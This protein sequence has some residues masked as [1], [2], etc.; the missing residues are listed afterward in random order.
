MSTKILA[1]V[2]GPLDGM[3]MSLRRRPEFLWVEVLCDEHGMPV[4]SGCFTGPGPERVLYRLGRAKGT[5]VYAGHSHAL[6]GGCGAFVERL[7]GHVAECSLCGTSL[8]TR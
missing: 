5:Y 4:R 7:D 6:C 1:L 3:A 8:L 2:D